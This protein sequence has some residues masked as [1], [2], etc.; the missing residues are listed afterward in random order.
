MKDALVLAD[1]NPTAPTQAVL[2]LL[3]NIK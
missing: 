3:L 1:E 2:K